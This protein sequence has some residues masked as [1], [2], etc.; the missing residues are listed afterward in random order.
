MRAAGCYI[1]S[2]PDPRKIEK[3]GLVNGVG[4]GGSVPLP[5]MQGHGLRTFRKLPLHFRYTHL[6]FYY[7]SLWRLKL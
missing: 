1:V 6:M 2:E 3:E 7:G 5:E 4:L